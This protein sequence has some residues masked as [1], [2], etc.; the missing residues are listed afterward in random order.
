MPLAGEGQDALPP[1]RQ[2]EI[3]CDCGE[4]MTW[5]CFPGPGVT[6]ARLSRW[7]NQ[8]LCGASGVKKRPQDDRGLTIMR[9]RQTKR[10]TAPLC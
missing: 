7:R 4:V 2:V 8:F 3:V 1:R 10:A 5:S 9:R 6:A